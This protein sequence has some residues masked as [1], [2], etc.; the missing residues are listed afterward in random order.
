[1]WVFYIIEQLLI[2]LCLLYATI[3][4]LTSLQ[5]IMIEI[6]SWSEGFFFFFFLNWA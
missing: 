2:L 4:S 5:D 3:K 6:Y 1:M